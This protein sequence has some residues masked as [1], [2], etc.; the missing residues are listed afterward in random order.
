[1][2][3]LHCDR[4]VCILN[5]ECVYVCVSMCLC[6]C[7]HVL[8]LCMSVCFCLCIRCKL[9]ISS[10]FS[11]AARKALGPKCSDVEQGPYNHDGHCFAQ[12]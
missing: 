9:V 11:Y 10:P 4:A 2:T 8:G 1:M 12:G 7:V 5:E 3:V 6:I